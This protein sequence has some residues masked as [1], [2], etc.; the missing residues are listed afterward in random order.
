MYFLKTVNCLYCSKEF[1]TTEIMENKLKVTKRDSDFCIHYDY[2]NPIFYDIHV[3]PHCG[4]AFYSSYRKL[5][6]PYRSIVKENYID[7]VQKMDLCGERKIE[8]A[9]KTFKLALFTAQLTKE[10]KLVTANLCLKTA[11]LYRYLK[12]E[13]QEKRF[14][15][16]ALK[17]F[18]DILSTERLDTQGIDE[19]KLI[20]LIADLS[21]RL[22]KYASARKWFSHLI[23]D[24]SV[25]KKYRNLALSR[26]HEYK[27][28]KGE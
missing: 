12:D 27:D 24:K 4:Y 28:K 2:E 16:L 11:W 26:W 18:T 13:E 5:I 17:D 7:K 8:D 9:I 23:T 3:C 10:R 22:N 1:K 15:R 21:S 25:S 20:Y 6:E 14:L 19:D